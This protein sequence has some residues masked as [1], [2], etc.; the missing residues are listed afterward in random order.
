MFTMFVTYAG[1]K[2]TRF[3]RN[4]WI[5]VH[6]PLVRECWE[7]HGL[8]S[9][10][11]FFPADDGGGFVAICP[12]IFKDEAAMKAAVSSSAANRVMADVVHFTNVEPKRS[13]L[14]PLDEIR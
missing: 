11:G 8:L 5:N 9:A 3:D 10:E 4:Y 1:H 2:T 14:Q 6:L 13:V 7:P 12:C